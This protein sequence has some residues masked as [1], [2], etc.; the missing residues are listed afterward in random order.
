MR[1]KIVIM[2]IIMTGKNER[3]KG[4]RN[5]QVHGG[6]HIWG[7]LGPWQSLHCRYQRKV[8]TSPPERKRER[9]IGR[10]EKL[11]KNKNKK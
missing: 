8:Q 7:L 1:K 6:G 10:K 3:E 11:K 5:E 4:G 9:K 2:M